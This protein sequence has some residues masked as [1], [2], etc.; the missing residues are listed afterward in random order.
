MIKK[1]FFKIEKMDL[2]QGLCT[3]R[4][5]NP[6]GP[7]SSEEMTLKEAKKL[8]IGNPNHDIIATFDI[9][10]QNYEFIS[11]EHLVEYIAKSYPNSRFEEYL[12]KKLADKP[13]TLKD[14]EN[15]TFEKSIEKPHEV[16]VGDIVMIQMENGFNIE[17]I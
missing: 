15:K 14:L 9:P 6:Y 5:I 10:M 16:D 11:A 8:K 1:T 12:M 7:I 4:H 2:E 17:T 3:V 13:D